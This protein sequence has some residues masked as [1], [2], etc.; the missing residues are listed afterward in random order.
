MTG[1]MPDSISGES[2]KETGTGQNHPVPVLFR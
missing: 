1:N 2:I